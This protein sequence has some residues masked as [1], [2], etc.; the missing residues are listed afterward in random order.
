MNF[1]DDVEPWLGD[2]V[3]VF[4]RSFEAD[5]PTG[6]TP[7]FAAMVEVDD[8]DAA[9]G[10][11][12]RLA[13]ADPA[14]EQ[15]RSYEGTDYLASPSGDFAAGVVDDYALVVGTEMSFKLAVDAA[16]GESLS[17]SEE[18]TSRAD[19]LPDDPLATAFFEPAALVA[20]AEEAGG[21]PPRATKAVEP[22]LAGA[23][24]QPVE[25]T[26]S[27]TDDSAS[28]DLAASSESAED[29]GT[30]SVLLDGLPADSWFAAAIPDLGPTLQR[31]VDQLSKGG[32]PGAGM[33][34]RQIRETTGIDLRADLL[35][36]LGD[37]ALFVQGTAPPAF[38][39]GLIAQTSDP[40]APRSLLNATQSLVEHGS[41]LRSTGPPEGAEYG[42]SIGLPGL[43][44]RRRGRGRRRRARGRG[45]DH[46]L[47]GPEAQPHARHR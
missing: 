38:S 26:L 14:Q 46:G 47:P 31:T 36:W 42:F 40:Q 2:E 41:G 3:G 27:A 12:Q 29:V 7:D 17:E 37:A 1:A 43:G 11:L 8:A 15:E 20:A 44:W 35:S 16:G 4:V 19:E 10:F 34:E 25:V 13:D 22:L 6:V 21:V 30:G 18:Y 39:A 9:R 45:G 23:L 33:L 24:S 5:P 28:I 32:L